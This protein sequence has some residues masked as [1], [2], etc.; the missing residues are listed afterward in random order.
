MNAADTKAP[1]SKI[2]GLLLLTLCLSNTTPAQSHRVLRPFTIAEHDARLYAYDEP[3]YF[4][5]RGR[6][7]RN[8][9]AVGSGSPYKKRAPPAGGPTIKNNLPELISFSQTHPSPSAP[10]A[11]NSPDSA[12]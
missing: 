4:F 5:D 12:P 9:I 1:L 7:S 6:W 3:F 8:R 2:T 11:P 10:P